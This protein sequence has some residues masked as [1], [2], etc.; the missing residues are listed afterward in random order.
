MTL[1]TYTPTSATVTLTTSP[2]SSSFLTFGGSSIITID[3]ISTNDIRDY[4]VSVVLT[5]T[6]ISSTFTFTLRMVADRFPY[7]KCQPESVFA[8]N[9]NLL[10]PI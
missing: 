3:S 5:D 9:N 1:P 4:I 7:F 8:V 10:A 6:G 2:S